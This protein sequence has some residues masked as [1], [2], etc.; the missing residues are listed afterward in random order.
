MLT[1]P[2]VEEHF[3]MHVNKPIKVE[4]VLMVTRPHRWKNDTNHL[5]NYLLLTLSRSV[6]I[7]SLSINP[8]ITAE[9]HSIF[10]ES[11]STC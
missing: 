6:H 2:K 1:N 3:E 11:G 9:S 8:L 4:L 7:S 5:C 10:Y